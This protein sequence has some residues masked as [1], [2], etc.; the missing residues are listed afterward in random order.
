MILVAG[1]G[2]DPEQLVE[3]GS[4]ELGEIWLSGPQVYALEPTSADH[5]LLA[6]GLHALPAVS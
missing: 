6:A 1:D 4:G 3:P 2:D 5:T